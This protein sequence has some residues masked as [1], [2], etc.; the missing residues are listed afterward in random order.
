[1]PSQLKKKSIKGFLWSL[2]EIFGIRSIRFITSII[3]AR[4]LLPEAFGLIGMIY[5]F[6]AIGYIFI[7]SGFGL[8]LIQHKD[9][10][11]ADYSTIFYFN[12]YRS[13][14]SSGQKI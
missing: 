13:R 11:Q 4:L 3:L 1:M 9:T 2:I 10:D 7:E 14:Y 12:F 5:I 6:I 8:A